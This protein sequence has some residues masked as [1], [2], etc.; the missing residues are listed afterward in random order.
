MRRRDIQQRELAEDDPVTLTEAC[1][2]VFRGT[3]THAS[4]KA[5]IQRGNLATFKI[6]R[7]IFTTLRDIKEMQKKCRVIRKVPASTSTGN[8]D[9][10]P[11]GTEVPSAALAALNQTVKALKSGLPNT[12]QLNI[13]PRRIRRP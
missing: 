3:I 5:E 2:I 4:L 11:S 7:T 12:S 13:A 8:V 10:G 9:N 6:G 1:D